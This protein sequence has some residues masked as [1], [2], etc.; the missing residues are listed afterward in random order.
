MLYRLLGLDPSE[1]SQKRFTTEGTEFTEGKHPFSV[2]SVSSVVTMLFA[3]RRLGGQGL[4]LL[5]DFADHGAQ[6]VAA[7]GAEVVE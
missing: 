5:F 2:S 4:G 1:P 6:A 7:G 3:E